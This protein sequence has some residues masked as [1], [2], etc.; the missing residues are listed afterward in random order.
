MSNSSLV[1]YTKLSPNRTVP[2][3]N[4]IDT[5]TIHM[6]VG[7]VTAERLGEIFAPVAKQ[8]SSNYG[9]DKDGRVGM[10]VEEANRSW[11]TGTGNSINTN[12]HR[13]V[14]IEVA[15]DT[16]SPYAVTEKAYNGTLDLCVDI[17]KRNG[18]NKLVF[19]GNRTDTEAA[20]K[21]P[22]PEAMYLTAHKWFNN[23][24]CPGEYLYSRFPEIAKTVTDKLNP[25]PEPSVETV[26]FEVTPIKKGMGGE[27]VKKVQVVL[28]G[29]GFYTMDIDGSAGGGTDR[30][31]RAYQKA[32]KLTEDGVLA[33]NAGKNFLTYR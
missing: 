8:A 24:S 32:N 18:K 29:L 19:L 20:W 30:A 31:I 23:T 7:Q 11:C 17:C 4:V 21:K 15:S 28:K 33:R 13:A 5:I 1:V 22:D 14:T 6:V 3:K 12:D 2:R 16:K 9:V 10:Y 25:Q 27:E 26:T